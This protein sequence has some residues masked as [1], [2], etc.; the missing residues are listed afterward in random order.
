[1]NLYYILLL[2]FHI[3]N[4]YVMKKNVTKLE[5]TTCAF[6]STLYCM[7]LNL[8]NVYTIKYVQILNNIVIF[9]N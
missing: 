5:F 3:F 9:T 4:L 8:V 6:I 2:Q 7:Q 1:M